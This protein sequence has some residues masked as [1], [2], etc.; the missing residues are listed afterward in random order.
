MAGDEKRVP[1]RGLAVSILIALIFAASLL[2]Q[3][4]ARHQALPAK[5]KP[6]AL[7]GGLR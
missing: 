4:W 3:M 1:A 2:W 5:T 7:N 6:A